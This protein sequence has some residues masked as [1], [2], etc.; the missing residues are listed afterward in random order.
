LLIGEANAGDWVLL[1]VN[2]LLDV[3]P[4]LRKF[5]VFKGVNDLLEESGRYL[6]H[7]LGVAK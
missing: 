6:G 5:L 3:T 1:T 2:R 7:K 4:K